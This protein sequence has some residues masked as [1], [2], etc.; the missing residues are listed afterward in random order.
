MSLTPGS[1]KELNRKKKELKKKTSM[2]TERPRPR[3]GAISNPFMDMLTP[4]Q[5]AKM[6]PDYWKQPLPDVE[7]FLAAR[8]GGNRQ[9]GMRYGGSG[10]SA[11]VVRNNDPGEKRKTAEELRQEAIDGAKI[12]KMEELTGIERPEEDIGDNLLGD[13]VSS[14]EGNYKSYNRGRAG[15]ARGDEIDFST[16]TLGEV[17]EMQRNGIFAVGKYQIIP[18]TMKEAVQKLG[19]D[20][21]I[22][23]TPELQERIFRD[24]LVAGKRPAIKDYITGESDDLDAANE[25]L[26]YEFASVPGKDGRG[27]YDGDSAGNRAN[28]GL[29]DKVRK[30]LEKEREKYAEAIA[31]GK[32][33]EEAWSG[34]SFKSEDE[35]ET[36]P[37]QFELPESILAEMD[38]EIQRLYR[39]G[40]AHVK[41]LI[42][43]T[44][45]SY[46]EDSFTT[47]N[48][49]INK[50]FAPG[51]DYTGTARNVNG[52]QFREFQGAETG[53]EAAEAAGVPRYYN[54][55]AEIAGTTN[56][57]AIESQLTTIESSTGVKFRVNKAIKG[58]AEG[59][60]R[61]LESMGYY[62][63]PRETGAG[64][65]NYRSKRGSGGLSEHSFGTALDINPGQNP[66]RST[67][68]NMPDNIAEIAAK[69]GFNWGGTWN[70]P[71]GMHFEASPRYNVPLTE[72]VSDFDE[73]FKKAVQENP[74]RYINAKKLAPHLF[75]GE[76]ATAEVETPTG[77]RPLERIRTP[78][79]AAEALRILDDQAEREKQ[80]AKEREEEQRV[81]SEIE[82]P[83]GN[84]EITPY[85]EAR[86]SVTQDPSPEQAT[87]QEQAQEQVPTA[88]PPGGRPQQS[89]GG[90][91][92]PTE[93]VAP[94]RR[95][96]SF[97]EYARGGPE[98]E[99]VAT[100][101][102]NPQYTNPSSPEESKVTDTPPT[103]S[104]ES[105]P[106]SATPEV[107]G[108][109]SEEV[110]KNEVP[111]E[112]VQ[113]PSDVPS[114]VPTEQVP[115]NEASAS[116]EPSNDPLGD[117]LNKG[118][119][120]SDKGGEVEALEEGIAGEVPGYVPPPPPPKT[121]DQLIDEQVERMRR[122]ETEA[123]P[124]SADGSVDYRSLV[125][126]A[127]MRQESEP[128][129]SFETERVGN[130]TD[131][132]PEEI[133]ASMSN[134]LSARP[135]PNDPVQAQAFQKFQEETRNSLTEQYGSERAEQIMQSRGL[136]STPGPNMNAAVSNHRAV[137][138]VVG[139]TA[140]P[141]NDETESFHEKSTIDMGKTSNASHAR[142]T[143]EVERN[144]DVIPDDK[145]L[146]GVESSRYNP[147]GYETEEEE[148]V[149]AAAPPVSTIATQPRQPEPKPFSSVPH[150]PMN[151]LENVRNMN[152]EYSPSAQR[153]YNRARNYSDSNPVTHHDLG[154]VNV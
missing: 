28:R 116:E 7:G 119:R 41:N 4:T 114:Q 141:V 97:M 87:E 100:A 120:R 18:S 29:L 26:A 137:S 45:T 48:E 146:P 84:R 79:E 8:Y 109:V 44:Y 20:P 50:K 103:A 99:Q 82:R 57:A 89:R 3:K 56:Q 148:D 71:D 9:G 142:K 102:V 15:D 131:H 22:K 42:A 133:R 121:G 92:V 33:P 58:N 49:E 123:I 108:N 88:S 17:M 65:Y 129:A 69:Y 127:G 35:N 46:G 118:I 110:P 153:A 76:D 14:G 43:N 5:L 95:M 37:E 40:D 70:N 47:I 2:M 144:S 86:Q 21:N 93:Q 39:N 38:P 83:P 90:N 25:A 36:A 98:E 136:I 139:N 51:D 54:D 151:F 134:R 138:A 132:L 6:F 91:E 12:K 73:A 106:P 16:K 111:T 59:L 75:E 145:F 78:E 147:D 34:L 112:Q 128:T 126:P 13:I 150:S 81:P 135:D 105:T 32:T 31:S 23:F 125:R 55:G 104:Q 124:I 53:P 61:E 63:D 107:Q 72:N 19:L 80:E 117:I 64:A 85:A 68:N 66:F 152:H 24:Y 30:G 154:N 94:P 1:I 27:K 10:G 101:D 130:W 67:Q 77:P 149:P 74:D 113:V 11:S 143:G 60:I 52:L 122:P 96:E 62:I 115:E 140:M